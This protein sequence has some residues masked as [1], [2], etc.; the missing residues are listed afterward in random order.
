[1]EFKPFETGF[2][3]QSEI[4]AIDESKQRE[5]KTNKQ[6]EQCDQKPKV[7]KHGIYTDYSTR[8]M[9]VIGSTENK[10]RKTG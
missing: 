3:E 9:P 5:E 4:E 10:P 8:F 6:E 7:R 2:K 1:M